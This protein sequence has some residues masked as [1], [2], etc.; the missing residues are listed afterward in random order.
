M[1]SESASEYL[2]KS[3]EG[4]ESLW[5]CFERAM[6]IEVRAF[7]EISFDSSVVNP[8]SGDLTLTST[9]YDVNHSFRD[10]FGD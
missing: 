5:S 2:E 7:D 6:D 8:L 3:D 4:E 10:G 9:T 1:S